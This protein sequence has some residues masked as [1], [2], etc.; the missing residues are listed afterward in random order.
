[1]PLGIF[2]VGRGMRAEIL[3][4]LRSPCL[5]NLIDCLTYIAELSHNIQIGKSNNFQPLGFQIDC[6]LFIIFHFLG[7]TVLGAV[8]LYHHFCLMAVK[9]NDIIPYHILSAEAV[10]CTA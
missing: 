3:Q 6:P 8:Q 1:M 4:F 2:W 9:I 5:H 7:A 10:F